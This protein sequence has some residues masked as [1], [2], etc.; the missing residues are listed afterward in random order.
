MSPETEHVEPLADTLGLHQ[1][2]AIPSVGLSDL[3]GH[4]GN[5]LPLVLKVLATL[6][7]GTGSFSTH[8]P[9]GKRWVVILDHE[10]TGEL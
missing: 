5:N 8:T 7:T 4:L 10:P 9:L 1:F 2:A 6:Q 3:L